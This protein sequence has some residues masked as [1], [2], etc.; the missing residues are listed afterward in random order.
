MSSLRARTIRLANTN[1][2]LRPL[3]LPLLEKTAKALP[4]KPKK[5]DTK[6]YAELDEDTGM[7]CAFGDPSGFCYGTYSDMDDAEAAVEKLTK[8]KKTAGNLGEDLNPYM[9]DTKDPTWEWANEDLQGNVE[10]TTQAVSALVLKTSRELSRVSKFVTGDTKDLYFGD[11]KARLI[12]AIE[13]IL[14][15]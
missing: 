1:P 15:D 11:L 6:F 12:S 10:D 14:P 8:G 9:L 5:P 7:Y 4:S 13:R 2:D 3:L